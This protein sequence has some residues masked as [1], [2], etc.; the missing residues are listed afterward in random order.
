M[1]IQKFEYV[2]AWQKAQ[3]L[4]VDVCSAFDNL[5]LTPYS[6]LQC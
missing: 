6:L 2:V 5:F 1:E 4:A 3:T